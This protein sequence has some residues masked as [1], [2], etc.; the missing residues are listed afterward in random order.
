MRVMLALLALAAAGPAAAQRDPD[1]LERG[2]AVATQWCANCHAVGPGGPAPR[3][4]AA[5][6]F[7]SIAARPGTT[8]AGVATFV[9]LPHPN[10]PDHGL[11]A[12]QAEDVAAF[13]LAQ[14]AR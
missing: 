11:T 6:S 12:R 5:P 13:L 7:A 9:R 2:R 10:M 8:R 1:Q 4:D 14:G 3:S